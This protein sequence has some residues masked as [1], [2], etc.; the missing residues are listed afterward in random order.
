MSFIDIPTEQTTAITDLVL[1]VSALTLSLF[2][3]G[4]GR[5]RDGKK[6]CIWSW[7]FGLL[8]LASVLGAAAHGIMMSKTIHFIIWQPIHLSLGLTIALFTAGVVYDIREY[9]LPRG[10]MPVILGI[11]VIFYLIT[12]LVSGGFYVFIIYESIAMLFALVSYIILA[13]GKKK[14]R[15]WLMAAGIFISISAAVIQASGSVHLTLI[16]EFDYNGIFHLLQVIGILFLYTGVIADLRARSL[17]SG[18]SA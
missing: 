4:I 10:F 14:S 6:S 3:Y 18:T 1:A 12:V 13:I 16:W 9:S 2:I 5:T 11:G 7:A 17:P 15:F 8:A